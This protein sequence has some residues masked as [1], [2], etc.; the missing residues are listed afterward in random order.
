ME[1][2]GPASRNSE[3]LGAALVLNCVR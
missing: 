3:K 1:E 2:L